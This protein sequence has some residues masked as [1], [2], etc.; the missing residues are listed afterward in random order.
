MHLIPGTKIISDRYGPGTVTSDASVPGCV[1]VSFSGTNY[2]CIYN[3]HTGKRYLMIGHD[4]IR[5]DSD[6][7]Q[8]TGQ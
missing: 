8:N 6:G 5:E 1:D 3:R 2:D 7:R 4:T